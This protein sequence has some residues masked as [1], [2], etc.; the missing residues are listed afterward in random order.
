M[1]SIYQKIVEYI[2]AH[3]KDEIS[4]AEIADAVG[5]SANHIYK[6]FKVYSPYP[7][8]EYIRR[9]RLYAAANEI[10]LGRKLYDIALDYKYESPSGF[11]KAFKNVLNCSPSEY[12]KNIKK[13]QNIMLIEHVKNIEELDAVLSYCKIL[14]PDVKFMGADGNDKYSR[15]FWIKQWK[16][17][18]EL[19]LF[20]RD[21]D[22]ICGIAISWADGQNI[23]VAMDGVSKEYAEMGLHEALLIETEKRAKLHKYNSVCMGIGEGKEEFYAKLGYIGKMLV[24]SEKYPLDELKAFNELY[25]NY[26]I[27]GANVYDGYVNQLWLNVSLLDKSIKKKYEDEIGDCWVQIIVCKEV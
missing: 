23:T 15:N 11:Y 6:L 17:N 24:Q 25:G 27:I 16:M 18:P 8:M 19:L 1:S 10:Y 21:N 26:E 4:I 5:Y 2:D 9:K 3:I 7:I 14:Y 20:A 22:R 12:K 13:G